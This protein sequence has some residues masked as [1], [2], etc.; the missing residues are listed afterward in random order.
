[1]V[2]LTSGE[3]H[4]NKVE[5]N[6]NNLLTQ[7]VFNEVDILGKRF[8]FQNQSEDKN[9]G[10]W[11]VQRAWANEKDPKSNKNIILNK[12]GKKQNLIISYA[13]DKM[14][15]LDFTL[16][17][18]ETI[19]SLQ[20]NDEG[21]LVVSRKDTT[22]KL[23]S[24]SHDL[25]PREY[26]ELTNFPVKFW[27]DRNVN[28]IVDTVDP[29]KFIRYATPIVG[30]VAGAGFATGADQINAQNWK[31]LF[32]GPT[33]LSQPENNARTKEKQLLMLSSEDAVIKNIFATPKE[34][35]SDKI[36]CVDLDCLTRYKFT[37][38]E[39][40][41][42][43]MNALSLIDDIKLT[44]R[45]FLNPQ[46]NSGKD[47]ATLMSKY[48]K[49]DQDVNSLYK[50]RK[51]KN[52]GVP[53]NELVDPLQKVV[54]ELNFTAFPKDQQ[55]F[56]RFLD[57]LQQFSNPHS[58]LITPEKVMKQIGIPVPYGNVT[59]TDLYKYYWQVNQQNPDLFTSGNI[60]C[61][62]VIAETTLSNDLLVTQDGSIQ[63]VASI[64]NGK[65]GDMEVHTVEYQP[66]KIIK[67]VYNNS[68]FPS[69]AISFRSGSK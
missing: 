57:A 59:G 37:R 53:T 13:H 23:N 7:R 68:N 4:G 25:T 20:K 24:E 45:F 22:G 61:F 43:Q 15:S 44:S 9:L 41:N 5:I 39:D 51:Y 29:S 50:W 33:P 36:E 34:K 12:T 27:I 31:D 55:N 48:L 62:S 30:L 66:G 47:M 42:L 6:R 63:I 26:L 3:I 60:N 8:L 2:G 35:I 16:S 56:Y 67:R 11:Q 28:A 17:D 32:L 18:G 65:N 40:R 58:N 10:D 19:V 52:N 21:K 1:M 64:I 49:H 69:G 54:G 14:T 38:P 46:L